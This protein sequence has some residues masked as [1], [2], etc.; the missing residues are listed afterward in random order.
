MKIATHHAVLAKAKKWRTNNTAENRAEAIQNLEDGMRRFQ[1]ALS[2]GEEL[3]LLHKEN[4]QLD[5]AIECLRKLERR[6]KQIGEETLCRWGSVLRLRGLRELAGHALGAAMADLQKA[7]AFFARAFEEFVTH[8][9]RINEL[10]TRFVRAGLARQLKDE[11]TSGQLVRSVEIDA[12]ALLDDERSLDPPQTGRPHLGPRLKGRSV[13]VAAR[14]GVCR[15]RLRR[16]DWSGGLGRVSSPV[17]G[18]TD[19]RHLDPHL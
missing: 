16:S 8:Y 2:L 12:K 7:E 1:D 10:T 11:T 3:V 19:S 14:L 5:L 9:S 6:F 4:G 18:Q 15:S 13:L 17:H